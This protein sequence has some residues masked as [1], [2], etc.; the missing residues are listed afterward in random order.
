MFRVLRLQVR[1]VKPGKLAEGS[2]GLFFRPGSTIRLKSSPSPVTEISRLSPSSIDNLDK[3]LDELEGLAR[4]DQD[5]PHFY[6][7]LLEHARQTLSAQSATLLIPTSDQQWLP[8]ASS[9]PVPESVIAELS[10]RLQQTV[11]TGTTERATW[12]ASSLQPHSFSKGCLVVVI[13]Q[14]IPGAALSGLGQVLQ[15]FAEIAAMRQQ[16]ELESFLDVTWEQVQG[17]SRQL[18]SAENRQQAAN[19]LV[20]GVVRLLG[21]ARVS[22]IAASPLGKI[23]GLRSLSPPRLLAIS[24]VP[25]ANKS[26]RSVAALQQ[27][28]A[29]VSLAGRPV[30]RQLPAEKNAAD[31]P[32]TLDPSAKIHRPDAPSLDCDGVFTNLIAVPL[33]ALGRS[34]SAAVIVIEYRNQAELM[35]NAGRLRQTLPTVAMAW[36]QQWRWLRLPKLLRTFGLA[37]WQILLALTPLVKWMLLAGVLTLAVWGLRQP[38]TLVV[39]AEG[40]Y[41]PVNA[42]AVYASDDGFIEALMIDDGEFVVLGQPLVQLRSS[43]LELR[44]EQLTGELRTV[45]EETSGVGIAINQLDADDPDALNQQSRLAGRIAELDTKRTSLQTQLAMLQEQRLRLLLTAPIAGSVVAKD[46]QRQLAGRPVRRGEALFTIVDQAGPW[47]VRLQVADR[48]SGYL[49]AHYA[50]EVADLVKDSEPTETTRAISFAFASQPVER[51]AASV[52]WIS[53]Q[54]E[55]R[56]GEGCFVEVRAQVDTHIE[57][58]HAGAGVHAFFPCGQQPL[59][60]VWCRPMVETI[61]RSVWFR[62]LQDDE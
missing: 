31:V 2:T 7:T 29:D 9:G 26:S 3:L 51:Y 14:Q 43:T 52:N 20:N 53:E 40:T 32:H 19:L 21:A 56:H 25:H 58:A 46:L 49:L 59:W 62:S 36:G 41:E 54:V 17:L 22:V 38:Q 28:A 47:Q 37:P 23:A 42:R 6:N 11:V 5:G 57:M 4:T 34:H 15:A 44:H 10:Q 12:L 18:M 60:F 30:L 55:N 45:V 8:M 13:E 35:T 1:L 61:Q 16:M 33:T 50:S 24:G 48:D 27:A 39:E